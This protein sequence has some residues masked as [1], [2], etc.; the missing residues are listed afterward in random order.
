VNAGGPSVSVVVPTRDR[1]ALLARCLSALARQTFSA[2]RFE[3]IVVRDGGSAQPTHSAPVAVR[4]LHHDVSRGP[5]AARNTGWR[6][7]RH[8][9][10][11]FLDDDVEADATLVAAASAALAQLGQGVAGV[12]GLVE[13]AD[14]FASTDPLARTIRA[15]GGGGGHTCNVAYWRSALEAV[16]GFDE[17]FP[18]AV[19]E[20][21]DLAYR[22]ADL[23]GPIEFVDGM[24]VTHAVFDPPWY[25]AWQRRRRNAW[26]SLVRLF[27]KHPHRFPP[28]FLP[29]WT[30]RAAGPLLR[31][32]SPL[33]VACYLVLNDLAQIAHYR[34]V[35]VRRPLAFAR[36][37]AYHLLEIP[38]VVFSVPALAHAY[39]TATRDAGTVTHAPTRTA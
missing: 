36:W 18:T 28:A 34:W 29:A 23:V 32:P 37:A 39:R 25:G 31:R 20:D 30:L 5:A 11:L 2:D 24:R 33:S 35:A 21:F 17:R 1:P 22:V 26:P 4:W 3:V 16:G 7:A 6:A 14:K 9:V 38:H 10:V 19:G 12:E 8:E 13:P 27:V 15:A